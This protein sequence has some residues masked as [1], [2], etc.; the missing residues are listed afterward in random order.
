MTEPP[1]HRRTSSLLGPLAALVGVF[2]LI[3]GLLSGPPDQVSGIVFGTVF[4]LAGV[5]IIWRRRAA[6]APNRPDGD[7]SNDEAASRSGQDNPHSRRNRE[8]SPGR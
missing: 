7:E 8:G 1:D 6:A 4:L 2:L 5:V 3:A